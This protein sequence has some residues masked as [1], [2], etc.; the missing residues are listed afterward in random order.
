MTQHEKTGLEGTSDDSQPPDFAEEKI[1]AALRRPA[2]IDPVAFDARVMKAVRAEPRHA[3]DLAAF[4]RRLK[5]ASI[6][7]A[8]LAAAIALFVIQD[9]R[10][11]VSPIVPRRTS[12]VTGSPGA[13]LPDARSKRTVTFTL[14]AAGASRVA[15]AGSFN[16]WSTAATP[17]HRIG[18]D[19][20]TTDIPLGTGRYV[21]QFVIDGKRWVADPGAPHDAG[22]DFGASNS[23]VTVATAG[24]A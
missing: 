21:Y 23:V 2:A 3:A 10:E 9:S 6:V 22:D 19:T 4:R 20:W 7:C 8:A 5:T 24:S 18:K 17:L 12:G 1:V 11:S 13:S 15:V 16:E 14:V